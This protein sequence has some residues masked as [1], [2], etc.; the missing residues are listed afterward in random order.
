MAN[1]HDT[2]PDPSGIAIKASLVLLASALIALIAANSPFAKDFKAFWD[3]PLTVGFGAY[4]ITDSLKL[5]VK[6][7]L[8]A[9]FFLHVGLEIKA[10]FME[11]ALA[12][13]KR[14]LMPIL[15]ALGG[16][17]V[18]AI[19]YLAIARGDP[20]LTKGWAIPTATDIAFAVGVVGLLGTRVPPALKAF[21][22]A[23]AVI[24]DLAAISIIAIFY[25]GA[26][27]LLP[28]V[29]TAAIAFAMWVLNRQ[30]IASLWPYLG[31]GVLMWIAI[32]LSGMSPT[33][34]GVITAAFILLAHPQGG[35]SPLHRLEAM[36][37]L[38]VLFAIM[39]IFALANAG[40]AL[41]G[42]GGGAAAS[43]LTIAIATALIVGKPVGIL[44]AAYGAKAAG[45]AELPDGATFRRMLGIG[46]L[47][48]IGFTM[49]LFVGYLAFGDGPQMDAVRL[50]VLSGSL[51]SA[52]LGAALL[53]RR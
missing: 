29:A 6:N 32:Y 25:S 30:S 12:D 20:T 45:I 17:V 40:V 53:W 9:I 39:P 35:E 27:Q 47:A 7:G 15:A 3:T 21:L 18:P 1:P 33:L 49:S 42:N 37:R 26:L 23:V 14:A 19:I 4:V 41:G 28:L 46:A 5:W 16:I 11:G 51:V 44:A 22:L 52:L 50:G 8:M 10:E 34:A 36:L 48:G 38:P 13:R 24:D 2:H 43:V 31:L